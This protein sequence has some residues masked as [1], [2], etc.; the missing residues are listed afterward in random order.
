MACDVA[1]QLAGLFDAA[2]LLIEAR[3]E[4]RGRAGMPV[5]PFSD[6]PDAPRLSRE[7]VELATAAMDGRLL[8]LFDPKPGFDPR[9][10][11]ETLGE[12][13]HYSREHVRKALRETLHAIGLQSPPT[14]YRRRAPA[15]TTDSEQ[16]T[17][18][19]A[20]RKVAQRKAQR[21]ATADPG[22]ID[23]LNREVSAGRLTWRMTADRG[24]IYYAP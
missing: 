5:S 7:T 23:L 1:A 11:D 17:Y 10:T 19:R 14:L 22:P 9:P 16:Q 20:R 3:K 15:G 2:E 6:L 4:G 13:I 8:A 21:Q 24:I 12:E 18:D